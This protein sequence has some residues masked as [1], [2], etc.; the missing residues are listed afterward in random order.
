[1]MFS[2]TS[3]EN[4]LM[5]DH[6]AS[7][8]MPKDYCERSGLPLNGGAVLEVATL[9]CAH[10]TQ[11]MIKNP[12]RS[13]ERAWCAQCDGYICDSCDGIRREPDYEHLPWRAVID[14]VKDGKALLVGGDHARPKLLYLK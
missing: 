8:G 4:Y 3:R 13:R 2:K 5:I 11:Q 9:T 6:R 12:W 1:M 14:L 10:C 7:P